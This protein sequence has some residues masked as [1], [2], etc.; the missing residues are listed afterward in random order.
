MRS[1][2]DRAYECGYRRCPRRWG[3]RC[4]ACERVEELR[5]VRR[6]ER[7]LYKIKV[8]EATR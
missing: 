8:K 3:M 2:K 5:R 1:L 7:Q 4:R 6:L